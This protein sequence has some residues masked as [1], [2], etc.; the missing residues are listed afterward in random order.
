VEARAGSGIWR[1][2][3]ERQRGALRRIRELPGVLRLLLGRFLY[4]DAIGTVNVFAIVYMSRLGGF[5]ESDKNHVTLVVVAFAGIGALASGWVAHRRGPRRTLLAVVPAFSLGLAIVAIAG[6]PWTVWMLAPVLGVALGTVYTVDRLFMLALTPVH[7]RGE[8]FGFFNL[9]GRVAQ[10]FGPF[11]LWGGTIFVLHDATGWLDALDA[12]RVSLGLIS[13][14][15]IVGLFV[16][17]PLSDGFSGPG[18][19]PEGGMKP[20]MRLSSSA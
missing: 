12:S 7:V 13:L 17:R 1:I 2:T 3:R 8:V 9:I 10:A 15:A 5:S 4:T 6:Q 16:V 14:A 18:Q 20:I 11:V 19:P